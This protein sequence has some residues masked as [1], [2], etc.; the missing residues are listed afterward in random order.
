[1]AYPEKTER[2]AR[3]YQLHN[4][5]LSYRKIAAKVKLKSVK[6]V[7]RIVARLRAAQ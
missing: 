7:Y 3:I 2:N 4:S 1:M 5:G 6:S